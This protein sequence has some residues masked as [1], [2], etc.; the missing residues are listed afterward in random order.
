M[1][2]NLLL[3]LLLSLLV[4]TTK[5]QNMT[6]STDSKGQIITTL[7]STVYNKIGY[8]Y[9]FTY[10]GSPYLGDLVWH[11]GTITLDNQT[12]IPA[13]LCYDLTTGIL[14][15]IDSS[16]VADKWIDIKPNA[17]TVEGA[18]FISFKTH[19]LGMTNTLY[20]NLIYDGKTRLLVKLHKNLRRPNNFHGFQ[21]HDD[22]VY[23]NNNQ[24]YLQKQD[25]EFEPI[26]LNNRSI[27]AKLMDRKNEISEFLKNSK[28]NIKDEKDLITV[29]KYYDGLV[30][31]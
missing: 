31:N 24:Y 16:S 11:L 1:K 12:V 3:L 5:A 8:T 17:F 28:I 13:T 21:S 26:N 23:L 30:Q 29:L 2:K 6:V 9:T 15:T 14:Y 20:G 25:G 10:I 19:F 4:P 27:L 18:E 7:T 22:G